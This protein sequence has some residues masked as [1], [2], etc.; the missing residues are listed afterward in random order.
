LL[1]TLAG[2]F[3][4]AC[5]I[6]SFSVLDREAARGDHLDSLSSAISSPSTRSS[7]PRLLG[8]AAVHAVGAQQAERL[9]RELRYQ[10]KSAEDRAAALEDRL[11]MLLKEEVERDKR[12]KTEAQQ[13]A[14]MEQKAVQMASETGSA[15]AALKMELNAE[16]AKRKAYLEDMKLA[17]ENKA[18]AKNLLNNA[19]Q[20]FSDSIQK[21]QKHVKESVETDNFQKKLTALK[22]QEHKYEDLAS[23]YKRQVPSRADAVSKQ[24]ETRTMKAAAVKPPVSVKAKTV[25][26][27]ESN[28]P[29]WGSRSWPSYYDNVL[30]DRGSSKLFSADAPKHAH[31]NY[32]DENDDTSDSRWVRSKSTGKFHRSQLA[33]TNSRVFRGRRGRQ[34]ALARSN[35]MGQEDQQKAYLERFE[36]E[37]RRIEE[38][39]KRLET[40]LS[41]ALVQNDQESS[42]E[43]S[44]LKRNVRI[45]NSD[46][47][48]E[49]GREKVLEGMAANEQSMIFNMREN[50]AK[51]TTQMKAEEAKR[52]A[53]MQLQMQKT[54]SNLKD[55]E[56]KLY[57]EK[58]KKAMDSELLTK[59]KQMQSA[60]QSFVD[61]QQ[62]HELQMEGE[63]K[64]ILQKE[65]AEK[66]RAV[67]EAKAL[68][69]S[70]TMALDRLR[71]LARQRFALAQEQKDKDAKT[72]IKVAREARGAV[73]SLMDTADK[74]SAEATKYRDYS[75]KEDQEIHSL[76]HE[77]DNLRKSE[78]DSERKREKAN[79]DMAFLQSKWRSKERIQ[80]KKLEEMSRELQR[81]RQAWSSEK[82][83]ESRV[84]RKQFL[85]DE[86]FKELKERQ[87]LF[88][89]MNAQEQ[90]AKDSAQ[91]TP[92]VDD[93][94]A[95][96]TERV[97][98]ERRE[99]SRQDISKE[100]ILGSLG[101]FGGM[102]MPSHKRRAAEAAPAEAEQ[103]EASGEGE[104][105]LDKIFNHPKD[106]PNFDSYLISSLASLN[107]KHKAAPAQVTSSRGHNKKKAAKQDGAFYDSG[108]LGDV[109]VPAK[110]T[111]QPL[112]WL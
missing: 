62:K 92:D 19:K 57:E 79:L 103:D 106:D 45:L 52:I 88:D 98:P 23:L 73:E 40:R 110:Q 91:G 69:E 108:L 20:L 60:M 46:L 71:E 14:S 18:D 66:Q 17:G 77:M 36:D 65:E 7:Y 97:R 75:Q 3:I 76:L 95:R 25:S 112:F 107:S 81:I 78:V 27:K 39:V 32:D 90:S 61:H 96:V 49:K 100:N 41:S 89:V 42:N 104:S 13:A 35:M 64:D 86:E 2:L 33:T 5:T 54:V 1:P 101:S 15:H 8:S 6:M 55:K 68:E 48:R 47:Q 93:A 72:L 70:K 82:Q 29:L 94:S 111:D 37:V 109:N 99:A 12:A 21:L 67:N 11:H 16:R 26:V 87:K 105:K 85:I 22:R 34:P 56:G 30:D 28:R 74:S 43:V 31:P 80:T 50:M 44:D 59:E 58:M 63:M 83:R 38:P 102:S 4:A 53:D 9:A 51:L 10:S 24:P 84:L